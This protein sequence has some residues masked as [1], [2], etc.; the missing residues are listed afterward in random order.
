MFYKMYLNDNAASSCAAQYELP[1]SFAV[2]RTLAPGRRGEKAPPEGRF[3]Q[4][5]GGGMGMRRTGE[6]FVPS[7]QCRPWW[8][9]LRRTIRCLMSTPRWRRVTAGTSLMGPWRMTL[10]RTMNWTTLQQGITLSSGAGRSP[11]TFKAAGKALRTTGN[12][13]RGVLPDFL[14]GQSNL[15]SV[16]GWAGVHVFT[17]AEPF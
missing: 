6:L 15:V 9:S 11:A 17:Q 7:S 16:I 10:M 1:P 8:T 4:Q 2:L 5:W 14:L 13:P 12:V 3:L